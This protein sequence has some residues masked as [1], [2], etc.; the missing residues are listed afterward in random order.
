VMVKSNWSTII[1]T[2]G[3]SRRFGSDKSQALLLG[4]SLLDEILL[5]LPIESSVIVVGPELSS[6]VREV[7]VT[8]ENP[9]HGGPVAG[10]SAGLAL[11]ET[12]SVG[13]IATDMPFATPVLGKLANALSD[14][15]DV[16]MPID[17]NGFRQPLCAVYRV[18]SLRA[19]LTQLGASHGQSMRNLVNLLKV[20]EVSIGDAEGS[21]L[22]DIDTYADL[23]R[24]VEIRQVL[25]NSIN[26]RR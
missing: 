11:V 18:H 5:A 9:I 14:E 15:V 7:K 3:T 8:R 26:E 6:P 2:G 10:I 1:L 21:P 19:A 20:K 16:V 24:A 13:V 25:D 17:A 23:E 4:H 12:E 22:M